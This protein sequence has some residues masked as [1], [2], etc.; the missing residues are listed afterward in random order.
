MIIIFFLKNFDQN[1][2]I[3]NHEF[4]IVENIQFNL[5][6]ISMKKHLFVYINKD[7]DEKDDNSSFMHDN[8]IRRVLNVKTRI[9]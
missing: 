5:S 7:F 8:Y 9:I 4:F 3:E 2:L 6:L 1:I